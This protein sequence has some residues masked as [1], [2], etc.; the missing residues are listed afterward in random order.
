MATG[1]HSII[2]PKEIHSEGIYGGIWYLKR[3]IIFK[4]NSMLECGKVKLTVKFKVKFPT[5]NCAK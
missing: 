4:A 5:N 3:Y 1:N 2:F